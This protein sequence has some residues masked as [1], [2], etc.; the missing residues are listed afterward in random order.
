MYVV[1]ILTY[2]IAFKSTQSQAFSIRKLEAKL[3]LLEFTHEKTDSIICTRITKE[4]CRHQEALQSIII[5]AE[6]TKEEVK[7]AKLEGGEALNKV[8]EWGK[9]FELK[10]YNADMEITLL[11]AHVKRMVAKSTFSKI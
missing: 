10:I 3:H 1:L 7:Q 9:E 6:E 11:K 2:S 5:G 4:I 8:K